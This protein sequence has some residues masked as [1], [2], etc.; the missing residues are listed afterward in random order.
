MTSAPKK[1][2]NIFISLACNIFLPVVILNKLTPRLGENGPL[3]ALIIALS[4]PIGYGLYDYVQRKHK[5]YISLLGVVSVLLTGG[6]AL[7]N[8][9]G[10]WFVIK[11][12]AFPFVLGIGVFLSAFTRRPVMRLMFFN[13][14][15]FNVRLI[16]SR[17]KESGKEESLRVLF[18]NSTFFLSLSFLLSAILNFV[19][20][21]R[22]FVDIDP[23][24]TDLERNTIL[25]QQIADM[26]WQSQLVILVPM[27]IVMMAILFYFLHRLKDLCGLTLDELM[28]KK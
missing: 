6:F 13:E 25:N 3:I 26:T 17:I 19:L 10:F 11:E 24:L 4:L 28:I 14:N 8:L 23:L 21:R 5:N 9:S 1:Q 2:E 20:A 15:V 16:E 7:F 27:M 22:I 18:K 12:A